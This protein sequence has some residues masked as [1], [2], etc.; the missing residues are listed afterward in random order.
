MY[1]LNTDDAPRMLEV[2]T[3]FLEKE[4]G[5][6]L[7]DQQK[8]KLQ[9]EARA[10]ANGEEDILHDP[11]LRR[12]FMDKESRPV[13]LGFSTL[14]MPSS[15]GPARPSPATTRATPITP[16]VQGG[17]GASSGAY[18]HASG[19]LVQSWSVVKRA[20]RSRGPR[21]HHKAT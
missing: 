4:S 1:E 7:D 8:S 21:T 11:F 13:E 10:L 6:V 9:L 3:S 18:F 5:L 16:P 15:Y 2:V 17:R 12:S 20:G 14:G 19:H